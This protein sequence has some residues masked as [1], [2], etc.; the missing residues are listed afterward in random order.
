MREKRGFDLMPGTVLAGDGVVFETRQPDVTDPDRD[1]ID[2][3][4][5]VNRKGFYG[6]VAQG[7]YIFSTCLTCF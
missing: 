4:A 7:I 5:F 6:V 2:T 3:K 1:G